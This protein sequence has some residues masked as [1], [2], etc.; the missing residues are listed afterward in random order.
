[1]IT[2]CQS[3]RLQTFSLW[4]ADDKTVLFI[5][6][7]VLRF[8]FFVTLQ[9]IE[10]WEISLWRR[11]AI[12]P[13][14]TEPA[15]SPNYTEILCLFSKCFKHH[16]LP[17][18][19]LRECM[20]ALALG[21]MSLSGDQPPHSRMLISLSCVG[22][23]HAWTLEHRE[24]NATAGSHPSYAVWR[25]AATH[26]V[27]QHEWVDGRPHEGVQG[28]AG[29]EYVERSREGHLQREVSSFPLII[30]HPETEA[31]GHPQHSIWPDC[32]FSFIFTGLFCFQMLY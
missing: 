21:C 31:V 6:K 3:I 5:Y 14:I 24:A 2:Y 16:V 11:A 19:V 32:W 25:W 12:R 18:D 23:W 13:S 4:K 30:T 9:I 28:P 1:M 29:Y 10:W 15:E 8:W 22:L 27:H 20:S 7:P 26:Q 17:H